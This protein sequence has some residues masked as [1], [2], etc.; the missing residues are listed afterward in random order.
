MSGDRHNFETWSS[1]APG[2][3]QHR[4]PPSEAYLPPAPIARTAN[5]S[6]A[7][8]LTPVAGMVH[9]IPCST[10][11]CARPRSPASFHWNPRPRSCRGS[12]Y[13]WGANG[14]RSAPSFGYRRP[15]FAVGLQ[16]SP[17]PCWPPHRRVGSQG[18]RGAPLHLPTSPSTTVA[19]RHA[20]STSPDGQAHILHDKDIPS[21]S[22]SSESPV[23]PLWRHNR[24]KALRGDRGHESIRGARD[25]C[26][27]N[28]TPDATGIHAIEQFSKR[29]QQSRKTIL[30]RGRTSQPWAASSQLHFSICYGREKCAS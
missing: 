10:S 22:P 3:R 25:P 30:T 23:I 7:G 24:R 9:A 20:P 12:R 26:A 13:K 2:S 4:S 8:A 18:A 11:F 28:M 19:A 1:F 15:T 6:R 29:L 16:P 21:T 5:N 14:A 27:R 17:S